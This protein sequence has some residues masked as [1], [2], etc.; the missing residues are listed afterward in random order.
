MSTL[1]MKQVSPEID[2]VQKYIEL[3]R[4]G[5][6][7]ATAGLSEAQW[8]FKPAADRWSIAEN[9]EHIVIVQEI[10]AGIVQSEPDATPTGDPA[11]IDNLILREFPHR[12]ARFK[13]PE[14]AMP[15]GKVSHQECFERLAKN[16]ALHARLAESEP[17]LRKRAYPAPP[18]KAATNGQ[19]EMLDGFQWLLV[20]AAH[21]ERHTKQILEVKADPNFP[22]P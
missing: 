3:T 15:Q 13:G 16:C 1:A 20:V 18:I 4:I 5:L 14:I 11:Y 19:Y 22:A 10:V 6:V 17:E 12:L 8:N 9:L 21:T 2:R 7:G